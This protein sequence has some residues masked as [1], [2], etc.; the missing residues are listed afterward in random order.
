MKKNTLFALW[1]GLFILCAVCG[2]IPS[3]EGPLR[4]A[5]TLL[6]LL[7]FLPPA[8]LL[9]FHRDAAT[10]TLVRNLSGLSLLVTL[11]ALVLN[12]LV[13]PG[14]EWLGNLMHNIL[15]IVSSPMICSGQW[16]L[17]LFL[18]ACLLTVSRKMMKGK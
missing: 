15:T 18:W 10:V 8:L 1:A 17:S 14:S 12:V 3:P 9:H 7:F 4:F 13:D 5:L 6:A 2:F 16:A 11:A